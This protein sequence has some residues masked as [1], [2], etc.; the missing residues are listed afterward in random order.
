MV[1]FTI[2]IMVSILLFIGLSMAI[3]AR[4]IKWFNDFCRKEA[5]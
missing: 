5:E 4:W 2:K 3:D 1:W